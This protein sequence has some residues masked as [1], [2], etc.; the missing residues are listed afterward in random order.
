MLSTAHFEHPRWR[1][2]RR[3]RV[4]SGLTQRQVED[5]SLVMLIYIVPTIGAAAIMIGLDPNG[6]PTNKGGLLFAAYLSNT[7]GTVRF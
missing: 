5:R 7:F 1:R 2:R 4:R 3:C 6:H